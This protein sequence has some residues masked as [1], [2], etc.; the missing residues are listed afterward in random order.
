[1]KNNTM[2]RLLLVISLTIFSPISHA[3][4]DYGT[5]AL[6]EFGLGSV[7]TNFGAAINSGEWYVFLTGNIISE[8]AIT[9]G[10]ANANIGN[11]FLTSP[12]LMGVGDSVSQSLYSSGYVNDG[13]VESFSNAEF[14]IEILNFTNESL[15]FRFDY[16][17]EVMGHMIGDG[18]GS[19][20]VSLSMED[21]GL[22]FINFDHNIDFGL[23]YGGGFDGEGASAWITLDQGDT[24]H[25]YGS[26]SSYIYAESIVHAVPEPPIV[27]LLSS[28]LIGL[29]GFAR[30]KKA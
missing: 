1:M 16:F 30:R 12:V 29:I 26:G 15:V 22:N 25:V 4:I 27:L 9:I 19:G 10:D 13:L 23:G 21:S 6:V 24:I 5:K 2:A 20:N 17:A 28:G 8:S 11:N 7:K 18:T 3:I 14:G